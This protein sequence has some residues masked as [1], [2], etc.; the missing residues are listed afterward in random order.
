MRNKRES[1][2]MCPY[3][4]G[5]QEINHDDGYGFEEDEEHE[6]ECVNCNKTFTFQTVIGFTYKVF[7]QDGDHD[8]EPF[9]TDHPGMYQC[10]KCDY[11]EQRL[12]EEVI[13]E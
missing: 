11:Y 10:K 7:C 5:Y 4:G 1:D 2:V 8:L 6:Q 13:Y 3:C 9:G 12:E